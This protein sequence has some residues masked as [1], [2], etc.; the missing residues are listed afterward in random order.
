V[1]EDRAV[2]REVP[3]AVVGHVDQRRLVGGRRHLDL[4]L[5]VI[6]QRVDG[7]RGH[8]A[9]IVLLAVGRHVR[10][11]QRRTGGVSLALRLPDHL[12]PALLAAVQVMRRVVRVQ[13]V[14]L[15]VELEGRVLDPVRDAAD[16][17]A[18]IRAR[19]HV[20]ADVVEAEHDVAE[21]AVLSGMCS[22]VTIAP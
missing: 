10:E 17:G 1:I 9:G 8:R 15:A 11:H 7:R 14:R 18:E 6:G 20:V 16:D 12:V 4:E 5:V 19:L 21:L 2:A 22:S 3:V 13:L